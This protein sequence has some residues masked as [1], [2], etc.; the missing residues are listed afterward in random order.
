MFR[1]E[2]ATENQP[3]S[4]PQWPRVTHLGETDAGTFV[5][6]HLILHFVALLNHISHLERRPCPSKGTI[7]VNASAS[8]SKH[9]VSD[10]PNHV[11]SCV[12]NCSRWIQVLGWPWK[13]PMKKKEKVYYTWD[14]CDTTDSKSEND[15]DL[16]CLLNL[17]ILRKGSDPISGYLQKQWCLAR[18]KNIDKLKESSSSC[19]PHPHSCLSSPL[20]TYRHVR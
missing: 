4:F 14:T 9:V 11:L 2:L 5:F 1:A 12:L 16:H 18:L 6:C 17:F 15:T 10:L 3:G 19:S 13:V 7:G 8:C 20:H